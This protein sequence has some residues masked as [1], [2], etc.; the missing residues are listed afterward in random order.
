VDG[1]YELLGIGAGEKARNGNAKSHGILL[2]ERIAFWGGAER[3]NAAA[4]MVDLQILFH[5]TT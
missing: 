3:Q 2:S 4:L 1:G 5:Y